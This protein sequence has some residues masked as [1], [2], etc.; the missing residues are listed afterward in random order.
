MSCMGPISISLS[1][2]NGYGLNYMCM[3]SFLCTI[4]SSVPLLSCFP[5]PITHPPTSV[6]PAALIAPLPPFYAHFRTF[7]K[8]FRRQ[9][10]PVWFVLPFFLSFLSLQIPS[11]F[12][13]RN[14]V[15]KPTYLHYVPTY[16]HYVPDVFQG[17]A[18][19]L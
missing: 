9:V 8:L 13:I 15:E 14:R 7:Q 3:F 5:G 11:N 18:L 16:L 2:M 17:P 19:V 1:Q 10:T 6:L 4:T 12:H